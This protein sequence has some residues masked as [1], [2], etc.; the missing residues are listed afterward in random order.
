MLSVHV[1]HIIV[2]GI[3]VLGVPLDYAELR[4]A[5]RNSHD[6]SLLEVERGINKIWTVAVELQF[7]NLLAFPACI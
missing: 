5:C 4:L 1:Y 3:S 6:E 2:L 7:L